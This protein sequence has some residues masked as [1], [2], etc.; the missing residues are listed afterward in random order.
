[1]LLDRAQ[2]SLEASV[3]SRWIDESLVQASWLIAFFEIS[4]HPLHSPIRVRS[5]LRMLDSLIRSLSMSSLDQADERTSRFGNRSVPVVSATRSTNVYSPT[6]G[7]WNASIPS[8]SALLPAVP[9]LSSAPH[10]PLDPRTTSPATQTQSPNAAHCGCGTL[11]LGTNWTHANELTPLWL[12]TPAWKTDTSD[13][14]IRRDECRRVVWSA[15]TLVAGY[16]SFV[17]ATNAIPSLDLYLMEPSNIALLFPG[18]NL[19]PAVSYPQ[20]SSG[21]SLS[22]STVWALYM[23]TMLLWHSCLRMRGDT[24]ESNASKAE[25]A[26]SAWLE[27]DNIEKALD[28]HTCG[29]E[30]AFLFQ[31]RE[32]LFNARMSISY[33]FQRYIPQVTADANLAFH[34]K[35]AED[36]LTHQASVAK[37]TMY[38]L[39]TITG[40]PNVTFARRPFFV[41]WFMSQVSRALLLWSCD[42]TLTIALEVS[43]SLIGPIEY[44]MSMWPCADQQ[45]RYREL[46]ANIE[47]ACIVAGVP[48]PS[49]STATSTRSSLSS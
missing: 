8:A 28:L 43:K 34:R 2:A 22:K 23:R 25:F 14:E 42:N 16:T 6:S 12:M 46:R 30:R 41:F 26:V 20:T 48:P 13:A 44:L 32:Y 1:M 9:G 27:V 3:N 4:A 7:H 33:E 38:G 29:I 39:Q 17:A 37:R 40:Q 18:E 24:N 19:V 11:T 45:R 49:P 21:E 10:H 47:N 5:A 31:G 35:K 15:V 36:W